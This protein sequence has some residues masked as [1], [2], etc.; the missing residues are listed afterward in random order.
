MSKQVKNEESKR[1][2]PDVNWEVQNQKN[3]AV[4]QCYD[5]FETDRMAK[6]PYNTEMDEMYKLYTGNHWRLLGEDGK[7]LRAEANMANHPNAV[8]NITFAMIE[9]LV[10]EFAAGK[11]LVDYPTEQEDEENALKL[12][13]LKEYIAYK[14]RIDLEYIKFLRHFFLYGTGIWEKNWDPNWK[15]GKGPNR[16]EGEIRWIADHPRTIF[17]DARCLESSDDGRRIHKATYWTKEDVEET[18]PDAEGITPDSV[19]DDI[20]VSEDLEESS[21]ETS[22]DQVLVV[23]TWYKGRPLILDEGEEDQGPGLHLI[24][25]AGEGSLKYLSHANYVHFDPGEDVEFP[26][27][28]Y[29]C[30]ERERSPWGIGE[31]YQIKNPQIIINK[32]AELIIE[33]HMHDAMGQTWYQND[34]VT[35]KQKKAIQSKG[36]LPGMWF[37]V[38]D[39]QGI[40]RENGR[41]AVSSL[42][43][44]SQRLQKVVETVIGRFD[45]SQGKTSG[46][47]T[48]FRALDLLAQRAQVRLNTKDQTINTSMEDSGNFI[49]RLIDRYYTSKRKYRILGKDDA[50]PTFGTYDPYEMKKAYIYDLDETVPLSELEAMT[51]G[52]E[53]LPEEEQMLEGREYEIYS[54]EFDTKCKTSSKLATDR[55]FYME[56]AKELLGAQLIDEEIFFYVMEFGKFPPYEE[57][58]QKIKDRKE[59]AMQMQQQQQ[60][61]QQIPEGQMPMPQERVQPQL[62]PEAMQ[63]IQDFIKYLQ[64]NRPDILKQLAQVPEQQRL[65][66]VIRMMGELEKEGGMEKATEQDNANRIKQQLI[67]I[68]QAE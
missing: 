11:E 15:G 19:S 58:M 33:S 20:V 28:L 36:T 63:Q 7:V 26:I 25:W 65:D 29:K 66:V 52:Q 61:Q 27:K 53:E 46:S 64:E 13:Q 8:E 18:W 32:T 30:Y 56:M 22:E 12:T 35:E 60:M 16:W 37:E 9:G 48:A 51:A 55:I 54:P 17:P 4:Y 1:D 14:N 68:A 31:A 38:L 23:D 10:A 57:L 62:P 47:V 59:Q 42:S 43:N 5:W 24:Q 49:N 50:K 3:K 34:A 67:E 40:H 2:S 41:N 21:A 6:Q 45:I 39:V 44:E